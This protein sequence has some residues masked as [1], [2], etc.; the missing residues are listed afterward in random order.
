LRALLRLAANRR[1]FFV[2]IHNVVLNAASADAIIT[3]L[4]SAGND[5]AIAAGE[6]QYRH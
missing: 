2:F 4:L 6:T 1:R 5:A 3:T